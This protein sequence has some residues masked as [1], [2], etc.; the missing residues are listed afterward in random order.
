M[1]KLQKTV[2]LICLSLFFLTFAYSQTN[3]QHDIRQL[4]QQGKDHFKAGQYGEAKATFMKAFELYDLSMQQ[5]KSAHIGTLNG[6]AK[7][8]LKE[9]LFD[10]ADALLT[11]A[12]D[13]QNKESG[14][15]SIIFAE[16]LNNF[17]RLNMERQQYG[18]VEELLDRA[19]EIRK[20][21]LGEAHVDYAESLRNLGYYYLFAGQFDKAESLLHEAAEIRLKSAGELSLEY[22]NS[23]LALGSY[24][25]LINDF[26]KSEEN[27][28]RCLDII[29]ILVGENH[30][31]YAE[32]LLAYS[33]FRAI[34]GKTREVEESVLQVCSIIENLY[35]KNHYFYA[36]ALSTLGGAYLFTSDYEKAEIL[37]LESLQLTKEIFGEKH[38]YYFNALNSLAVVYIT[39]GVHEKAEQYLIQ[40][41]NLRKALYGEQ[42]A[43]VANAINTLAK[44]YMDMSNYEQAE[45]LL[46]QAISMVESTIG[47]ISLNYA[48]ILTNLSLVY[49]HKSDLDK[50]LDYMEKTIS[51]LKN[52]L[53]ESHPSYLLSLENYVTLLLDKSM[54]FPDSL[55]L[56]GILYN[57]KTYE[58]IMT[59]IIEKRKA[60]QG[61][62]HPEYVLSLLNLAFY[63]YQAHQSEKSEI[64]YNK[65]LSCVD[66][67]HP[68]YLKAIFDL[69]FLKHQSANIT[70]ATDNYV[71]TFQLIKNQIVQKVLFL[72]EKEQ[73]FYW[74][75]LSYCANFFKT[76]LYQYK[77][78][79]PTLSCFIYNYELFSKSLLLN[80]AR[81]IRQSIVDNGGDELLR[82]LKSYEEA[83]VNL[84]SELMKTFDIQSLA[85]LYDFLS[86]S[87]DEE[88]EQMAEYLNSQKEYINREEKKLTLEY[89]AYNRFMSE[90]SMEWPEIQKAL[91]KDEVAIEFINYQYID[92]QTSSVLDTF[93]S[94]LLLNAD[95]PYPLMIPLCNAQG[96]Q[97]AIR[98][99]GQNPRA[100]YAAIWQPIENHLH[101]ATGIYIAPSGLLHAVSFAGIKKE[102]R[103]LCDDYTIHNVLSTKDVIRIKTAETPPNATGHAVLIGGSDYGLSMNELSLV[104]E[105]QETSGFT[106]LTRSMLDYMDSTRGQ[107]FTYLPGSLKEV[108]VIEQL[109][110]GN[111]WKASL[112]TD[113]R[114]TE[115]FF[116]SI[117]AKV[118]VPSP[119]LIHIS[120]H[121]F[122]LPLQKSDLYEENKFL[123]ARETNQNIYRL[124][125][126]PLM[127]TGLVF[128]G[129]NHV[130]RGGDV[131]TG[132]DDGILTAYEISNMNLS[133]TELVVLSACNTGLGD[134]NDS[135]GVFGLQR[136]FRMA[137][138]QTLIVS[139]W[140]APDRETVELMTAFY[141]LW[142]Q[143]LDKKKAFSQAQL[144]IRHLYP[145]QPEKW[146]GFIM[147]E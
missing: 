106:N 66:E 105:R 51:I 47:E 108:Q 73:A 22:A 8:Y 119:R 92:V 13:M 99:F 130:W 102:I 112:Y 39:S 124:S 91:N 129:A 128:S 143:G 103:Y 142:T 126:N 5:D 116:K 120:T 117:S 88:L 78:V 71:K 68:Y 23:L 137:G 121:G 44:Y 123:L 125:A 57:D 136:A 69:G 111:N 109:L 17:A 118:G 60:V 33:N 63:Y 135:E 131:E 56:T 20:R 98:R 138:V 64:L 41:L 83:V 85:V 70:N 133:Q 1:N 3:A 30:I 25:F 145:D 139:L 18:D 89:G 110:S 14:Q 96:L 147:I 146:A 82:L 107:G 10:K 31:D 28:M 94:A 21:E 81:L 9:G 75:S 62:N 87:E 27:H 72:S 134:I 127:R 77:D 79:N 11:E 90:F 104:P 67:R 46:H 76:F 26:D 141:S 43:S 4:N 36:V 100:L 55:P 19:I 97:E 37:L 140:E 74:N 7:V 122:F 61:E 144:K 32:A 6:L 45:I 12:L 93:Y 49:D 53:Y 24:Y 29:R 50:A 35:D 95:N 84:E 48:A 80:S 115:T 40:S 15:T 16:T 52:L 38:I 101:G 132:M 34:L 2:F 65:A 113:I 59:E 42:H 114:A 54:L 86:N 58:Q